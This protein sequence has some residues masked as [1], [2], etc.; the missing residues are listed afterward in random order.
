M[1]G[2]GI[3][4]CGRLPLIL[5]G[6]SEYCV[7]H[8]YCNYPPPVQPDVVLS[9]GLTQCSLS[10]F[11]GDYQIEAVFESYK[12]IEKTPS[13]VC[14]SFQVSNLKSQ[15]HF[16]LYESLYLLVITLLERQPIPPQGTKANL[17][18]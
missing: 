4:D 17:N 6:I 16:L 10:L 3:V 1:H 11:T 8:F 9:F 14:L 12:Q 15:Q 2:L 13:L 7:P 18:L 5:L